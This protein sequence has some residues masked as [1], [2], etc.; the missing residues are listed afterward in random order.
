MLYRDT[1][2]GKTLQSHL[3]AESTCSQHDYRKQYLQTDA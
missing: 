1:P 2:L 3:R